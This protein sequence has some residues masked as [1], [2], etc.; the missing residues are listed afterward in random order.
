M[1]I[2]YAA[3]GS[4]LRAAARNTGPPI[5]SGSRS[6]GGIGTKVSFPLP[7]VVG[8][9][10]IVPVTSLGV[11]GIASDAVLSAA[12][13]AAVL[14][15]CR[16]IGVGEVIEGDAGTAGAGMA[17]LAVSPGGEPTEGWGSLGF[18]IAGICGAVPLSSSVIAIL[19]VPSTITTTLAPTS[20]ERILEVMVD[21]PFDVAS[22]DA[23]MTA[24]FFLAALSAAA[25]AARAALSLAGAAAAA[26]AARRVGAA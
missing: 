3:V 5:A 21:G 25:L 19:K 20:S 9:D 1:P 8:W 10:G 26:W 23:L 17:G 18:S 6:V 15:D 7:G 24:L 2:S 12:S 13:G 14:N 4:P 16:P 22:G 11:C